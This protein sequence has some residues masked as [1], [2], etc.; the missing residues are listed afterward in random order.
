MKKKVTFTIPGLVAAGLVPFSGAIANNSENAVTEDSSMFE[1]LKNMILGI[2]ESHSYTLAQHSSHASHA[3]HG[4]HG[5]HRSAS[6]RSPPASEGE[7][8]FQP[9]GLDTTRNEQST[10]PT[11]VLPSSPA[12]AKKLKVLPGNSAKFGELVTRV[13]LA[14]TS[15]GYEVGEVDGRM[16]ARTIAAVYQYQQD[17][18]MIPSGKLTNDVLS[19]LAIVAQ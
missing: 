9:V 1:S 7:L 3:S 13:Q 12:I 5:S 6:Y 19:S 16:H 14:L 8:E 18:G 10:P 11:A 4:S 2:D 15:R 17:R